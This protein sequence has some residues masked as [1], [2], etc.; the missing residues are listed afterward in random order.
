MHEFLEKTTEATCGYLQ[1]VLPEI[2]DN[3]WEVLVLTSLNPKQ[4]ERMDASAKSLTSLDLASLLRIMDQNWYP[5]SSR[6]KYDS[7]HRHYLKEMQTIRNRWAHKSSEAISE[8]DVYRDLDTLQRFLVMVNSNQLL[9]DEIMKKK[10]QLRQ[11]G[12]AARKTEEEARG[13]DSTYEFAV[14]KIVRLKSDPDMEGAVVSIQPGDPENRMSVFG[15]GGLQSYYESQLELVVQSQA[16]QISIEEF[17][18]AITSLQIRHPN[19]STLYSLNSARI[20]FIPYQFR[21]VLK[22]IRSDR[23]RLLIADS[24]GVG[25]TIEACLILR[26]LQARRDVQSVLIICPKPLIVEKKWQTELRRFDESFTQMNSGEFRLCLDE[27]NKEGVWLERHK[28]TIVPYSLFDDDLIYGVKNQ[29]RKRTGLLDLDPPPKFDLVIVDEAHHIRNEKTANHKAVKFFCDNAEAVLCLTATPIQLGNKDLY[30]L[31]NLLRPDLIINEKNFEHMSEPNRYINAAARCVRLAVEEWQTNAAESLREATRTPW[32]ASILKVNPT[33]NRLLEDL[34]KGAVTQERRVQMISEIEDLHTFNTMINRTRRRDIESITT[35]TPETVEVDFTP[36]QAL[37]HD[38]LLEIQRQILSAIHGQTS[39]NFMMS[40]IKRQAASCIF[41]LVPFLRDILSRHLDELEWEQMDQDIPNEQILNA[42]K[43]QIQ[44]MVDIC[45]L[46]GDE[47]PKLAALEKIIGSKQKLENNKVMVFSSFKHTLSYLHNNL[48]AKAFRVGLIH[49]GVGDEDRMALRKRFELPRE[50]PDC[51]DVMLFSEV[52]CEGLDYQFCDT[53]INYDLPWNPMRIEQRIGRI[54]RRGQKS[55]K[56]FIFN[57]VTPGT[58]DAE[59]YK[60]C[61]LRIGIFE[62]SLGDSESIL[63]EITKQIKDIAENMELTPEQRK[64]LLQQLADNQI[65]K[66]QE[67]AKLEQRQYELFGVEIPNKQIEKDIEIATSFW[68]KPRMLEHMIQYYLKSRLDKDHEYLQGDKEAKNLR[69]AQEARIKLLKDYQS[70]SIPKSEVSRKWELYLKGGTPNL[71]VTFE[72][73]YAMQDSQ[74]MLLNPVHPLVKQAAEHIRNKEGS[75]VII[76][77]NS[78]D[79]LP[80]TYDFA[81][82]QWIMHGLK[83]DL[84]LQTV[85]SSSDVGSRLVQLLE[86]AKNLHFDDVVKQEHWE[87]LDKQHYELWTKA[88]SEHKGRIAEL[89]GFRKESL[90]TTHKA[91]IAHIK[92]QIDKVSEE[93]ILR[94]HQASLVNAE[95]DFNRH[96]QALEIAS[97]KADIISSAV[98]H[99]IITIRENRHGY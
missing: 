31:L 10:Q 93:K 53:M 4:R 18:A 44:A 91:R 43:D 42:I 77:T 45:G 52:G 9:I 24:V 60:R 40:T 46:L 11:S 92:D 83:N 76:E 22:F 56:V 33:C 47:D 49:G 89:V 36:E 72:T 1:Q 96:I 95:A 23:P 17:H 25:K 71:N 7:E 86:K 21:P 39:I 32:G 99:G 94:M 88:K 30:V 28:K 97:E 19:L 67:E 85:C 90:R 14:G 98:M 57:M 70:L 80:G 63:G 84:R 69:L 55:P 58:I 81:I 38:T 3:W 13:T 29:R 87:Y 16:L 20:D 26:E 51:L 59:I 2:S 27:Y 5:L 41:G 34:E 68:L 37:V 74:V 12:D 75:Y 78:D 8:D 73:D 35:R 65:R 66:L 6:L 50:D 48:I 79:V 62:N 61:L 54:D 82:Y 15:K 64:Q